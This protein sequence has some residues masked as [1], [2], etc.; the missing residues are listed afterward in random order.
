MAYG[1]PLKLLLLLFQMLPHAPLLF[2]FF[3]VFK[4]PISDTHPP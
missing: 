2:L 3:A 1:A 4:A